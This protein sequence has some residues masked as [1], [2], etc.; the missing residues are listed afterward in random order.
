MNEIIKLSREGTKNYNQ[1]IR[2]VQNKDKHADEAS[3]IVTSYFMTQRLSEI[4]EGPSEQ[5]KVYVHKL[6]LLCQI[7]RYTMKAKQT[8]DLTHIEKLR[9]LAADFRIAYFGS[10][11]EHKH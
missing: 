7:L 3:H 4:D 6:S 8:T 5:F 9:S 10:E 1:I 11:G 2:W